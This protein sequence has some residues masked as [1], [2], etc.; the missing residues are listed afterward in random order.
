MTEPKKETV[1]ISK[2][3]FDSFKK[4]L[5][6]LKEQNKLLF[7]AA[8]KR[9]LANIYARNKQNLPIDVRLRMLDGKV[10]V[11]WKTSK[12][13][14]FQ[15]SITRAWREDQKVELLFEDDTSKE[16]D[17]LDYNRRYEYVKCKR[18]GVVTDEATGAIFFKLA[19]L[20]N[21]KEYTVGVQF[22]N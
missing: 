5:E 6:T 18:I 9:A 3:T 2:E 15:D 13:E 17:L 20:D 8:D 19:R 4:E 21:G 7:E 12:N 14:V 22:V 11:G 1:E 16:F 10:I